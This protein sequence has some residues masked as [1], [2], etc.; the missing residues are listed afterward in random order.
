M[1]QI[2]VLRSGVTSE[3]QSPGVPT[4]TPWRHSITCIPT[5]HCASGD[6]GFPIIA[7]RSQT[8]PSHW[9]QAIQFASR[10]LR[11]WSPQIKDS[12]HP[13]SR[14]LHWLL[15]VPWQGLEPPGKFVLHRSIGTCFWSDS[16]IRWYQVLHVIFVVVY[17]LMHNTITWHVHLLFVYT[18]VLFDVFCFT[19]VLVGLFCV[20]HFFSFLLVFW[21]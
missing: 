13:T 12:L 5:I 14:R 19:P 10:I 4:F 2:K 6:F 21:E 1:P 17:R 16:N 15:W 7:W 9:D 11:E 8:A 20:H 18:N 3:Y